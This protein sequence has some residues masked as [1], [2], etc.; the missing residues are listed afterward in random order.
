MSRD[1]RIKAAAL[2][3]VDWV[4]GAGNPAPKEFI[5]EGKRGL[6]IAGRYAL[7]R[8]NH[9][10]LRSG[11][12]M[13]VKFERGDAVRPGRMREKYFQD[14]NGRAIRNEDF[15]PHLPPLKA[16]LAR[17]LK[18]PE[19]LHFHRVCVNKHAGKIAALKAH[20]DFTEV[21]Q[22]IQEELQEPVLSELV[23]PA[24]E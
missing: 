1:T 13:L 19:L 5:T 12:S 23:Q 9:Y 18:E 22:A 8:V 21:W 15:L 24:A 7:A 17:L 11:E 10:T 14:R 20:P 3:K 4:D 2:D 6:D 16:E